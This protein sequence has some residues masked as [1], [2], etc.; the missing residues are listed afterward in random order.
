MVPISAS[1]KPGWYVCYL[2]PFPARLLK[3]HVLQSDNFYEAIGESRELRWIRRTR[4][5]GKR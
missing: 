3:F 2:L 4:L 5:G 1:I